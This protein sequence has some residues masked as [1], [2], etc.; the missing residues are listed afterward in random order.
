MGDMDKPLQGRMGMFLHAAVVVFDAHLCCAVAE[1]SNGALDMAKANMELL[2]CH[3]AK[4]LTLGDSEL[5]A[6]QSKSM[7][8]TVHEL[9]RHVTSPNTIVR[10]Q[11]LRSSL[12][13]CLQ[14]YGKILP[15]LNQVYFLH[16]P[17]VVWLGGLSG[18]NAGLAISRS[19]V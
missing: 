17:Q 11:V 13:E 12:S 18:E 16:C 8:D 1:V 19:Q 4:P 5:T 14:N 9:V 15:L 2:L 3:C 10:D 7:F 6:T